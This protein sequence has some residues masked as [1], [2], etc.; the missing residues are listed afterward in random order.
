MISVLQVGENVRHIKKSDWGIG[1]IVK[2][3]K[4]GTI[5]VIFEGNNNLSIAQGSKHL[6]K[7]P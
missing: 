6:T 5:R 4:G 2:I 3:E 1:K 7:V